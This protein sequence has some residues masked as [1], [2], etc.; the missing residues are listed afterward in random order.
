MTKWI[1]EYMA[2]NRTYYQNVF[3]M[4]GQN[5]LLDYLFDLD[6]ELITGFLIKKAGDQQLDRGFLAVVEYHCYAHVALTRKWVFPKIQFLHQ[7]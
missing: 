7:S 6:I 1:L 2:D 4:D 3:R 5:S